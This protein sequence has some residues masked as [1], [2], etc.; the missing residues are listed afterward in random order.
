MYATIDVCKPK[1]KQ[2]PPEPPISAIFNRSPSP[3]PVIQPRTK[4]LPPAANAV[5]DSLYSTVNKPSRLGGHHRMK[6]DDI[7]LRNTT[8]TQPNIEQMYSVVQK[9][10]RPQPKPRRAVTPEEP[11]YSVPEKK[12]KKPPPLAPKPTSRSPT[13]TSERKREGPML[14][15][16][17]HRAPNLTH[18]RSESF[19]TGLM[20]SSPSLLRQD[21]WKTG[22]SNSLNQH[23]QHK[24]HKSMLAH[25]RSPSPEVSLIS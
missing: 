22:R 23:Q 25:Q 17:G 14:A 1:K 2:T 7:L 3:S 18:M 20:K 12:K 10:P 4:P 16:P 13:P 9:K 21:L 11:M 24:I 19:D 8:S 5:D 15:V 6:S